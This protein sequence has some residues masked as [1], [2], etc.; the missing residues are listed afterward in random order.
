MELLRVIVR[1]G[2]ARSGV[3]TLVVARGGVAPP[4]SP[5]QWGGDDPLPT[6]GN[7]KGPHPTPLHTCPYNDYEEVLSCYGSL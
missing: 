4:L 2:E 6:K 5:R 1:A 3:G 7:R